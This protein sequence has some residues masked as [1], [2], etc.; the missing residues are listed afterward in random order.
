M[1]QPVHFW[2]LC[3]VLGWAGQCMALRLC[4]ALRTIASQ[5]MHR[6]ARKFS[7]YA[8]HARLVRLCL[9]V[10]LH[11]GSLRSQHHGSPQKPV[12]GVRAVRM[13]SDSELS[14]Y[15]AVAVSA[16]LQAGAHAAAG[17]AVTL[18]DQLAH[19]GSVIKA[20][21]DQP[22]NVEFKGEGRPCNL[23]QRC[24][25]ACMISLTC[26]SHAGKVDLVTGASMPALQAH[27]CSTRSPP[28]PEHP[29][30]AQRRTRSASASSSAG[31]RR[32]SP[33]TPSSGRRSPPPRASPPT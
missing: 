12:A 22:K 26:P 4:I 15:S 31:S 28:P 25:H 10:G 7:F 24:T 32:P 33:P 11:P 21:F 13:P 30:A 2:S 5:C 1:A 18:I 19:A 23:F 27:A 20:S 17:A 3:T 14:I 6:A 29:L 16:A 9:R 8:D